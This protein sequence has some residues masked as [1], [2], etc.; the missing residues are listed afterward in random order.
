M[1]PTFLEKLFGK[2]WRSAL[3]G[4]GGAIFAACYPIMDKGTFNIH[5]D[6]KYLILAAGS[7]I[8]GNVVKDA[9]VTGLPKSTK[10]NGTTSN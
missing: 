8:F 6:W 4:Y 7:A 5:T 3:L 9:K 2:S 10:D 1:I